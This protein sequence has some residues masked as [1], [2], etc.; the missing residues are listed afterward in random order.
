MFKMATCVAEEHDYHRT[1]LGAARCILELF[2]VHRDQ[3]K[4]RPRLLSPPNLSGESP[5]PFAELYSF[6]GIPDDSSHRISYDRMR[7]P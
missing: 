6:D 5:I 3:A 4:P 7:S 1:F 2:P